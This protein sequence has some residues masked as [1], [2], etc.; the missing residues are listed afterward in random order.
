MLTRK[1]RIG[2]VL[3]YQEPG[4]AP[5]DVVVKRF[6][7]AHPRIM[8]VRFPDGY[9]RNGVAETEIIWEF[10]DGLNKFLS[11]KEAMGAAS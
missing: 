9:F 11:H 4:G 5:V 1:P 7:D 6:L 8:M 3:T 2:E 10:N